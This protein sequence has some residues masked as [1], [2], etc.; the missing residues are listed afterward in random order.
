MKGV[1]TLKG[2]HLV[3]RLSKTGGSHE[4]HLFSSDPERVEPVYTVWFVP[5]RVVGWEGRSVQSAH[6]A[7][8][9]YRR[10]DPLRV[11]L[12]ETRQWHVSTVNA[13]VRPLS[14]VMT[15]AED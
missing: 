12:L 10:L 15:N 8:C 2:S 11:V 6:L 1:S 9:G 7:I 13:N 5:V 3:N 4:S 14:L